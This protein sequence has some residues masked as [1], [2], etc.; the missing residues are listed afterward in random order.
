VSGAPTIGTATIA[1]PTSVTVACTAPAS[2]G[3]TTITTYTATAVGTAITGTLTSATCSTAIT[4][5]GLTTG[6]AYTFTVTATNSAGTSVASAASNSVTPATVYALGSTGPGGGLVFY[7]ASSTF[8]SAGSTCN[9]AGAGGISTCKYLEM[10]QK[11]WNGGTID[12]S[13]VLCNVNFTDATSSAIGTGAANTVL[14]EA[15]S[16]SSGIAK[17]VANYTVGGFSD[18]FLGSIDEVSQMYLY[19]SSRPSGSVYQ[20]NAW[21]YHSSTYN[22]GVASC[23]YFNDGVLNNC[24]VQ[25]SYSGRPIRVFG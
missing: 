7:V 6:T 4:V 14:A 17:M 15:A 8:A 19:Q 9:T 10:T 21:R 2:N 18:W 1:S 24:L 13:Q 25:H 16:C 3:G 12:P 11:T 23:K 5:S 20:F 22:G